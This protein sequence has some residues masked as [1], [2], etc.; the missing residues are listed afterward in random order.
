MSILLF[1]MSILFQHACI[2][3]YEILMLIG[4][5]YYSYG[6]ENTCRK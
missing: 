1:Q 4:I 6:K 3:M 5:C 2:N